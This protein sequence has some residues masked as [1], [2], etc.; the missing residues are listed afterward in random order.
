MLTSIRLIKIPK[1]VWRFFA[2]NSCKK[3]ATSY[4]IFNLF[5]LQ[6]LLEFH[7]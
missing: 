2:C 1:E 4:S 6:G 5:T 7:A 3:V